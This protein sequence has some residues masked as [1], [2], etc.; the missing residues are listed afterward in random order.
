MAYSISLIAKSRLSSS[1][2][3]ASAR[4]TDTAN[5][6]GGGGPAVAPTGPRLTLAVE[7][8]SSG[9]VS[10]IRSSTR[11]ARFAASGATATASAS[12][13]SGGESAAATSASVSV[14]LTAYGAW[15]ASVSVP[16]ST[17][18]TPA[19]ARATDP[20]SRPKNS[21]RSPRDSPGAVVRLARDSGKLASATS[22]DSSAIGATQADHA[23]Q[24]LGSTDDR[25]ASR[26]SVSLVPTGRPWTTAPG[27]S[28]PCMSAITSARNG[29]ETPKAA[30]TALSEPGGAASAPG[31]GATA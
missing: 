30:A 31:A 3:C 12:S 18:G 16:V 1:L 5:V 14:A 20:G 2:P 13:V 28:S 7:S 22:S 29:A 9:S 8:D 17:P 25:A 21:A 4:L 15:S 26:A 19:L 23:A 11:G 6:S 24:S 27:S 10:T